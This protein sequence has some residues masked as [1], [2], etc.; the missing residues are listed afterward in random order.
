[1]RDRVLIVAS[2]VVRV[3]GWVNSLAAAGFIVAVALSFAFADAIG[4]HLLAKYP[5][6]DIALTVAMLRTMAALGLIGCVAVR[7][8]LVALGAILSSVRAGDPFVAANA[9]RL[10]RI[11]W[12]LLLL[13]V[14]DLADGM[15]VLG[16]DRL[17]V[18]HA[19]WVP[20][21]TGWVAGLMMFVLARVFRAGAAM[22]DDLA[23][24]I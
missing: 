23:M 17:G 13:Q 14:L 22:R 1:M 5:G 6:H 19:T 11:G 18:D 2:G 3:A 8:I 21:F 10:Q 9:A 15:F 12:A 16:F 4:A 24:T 7:Q 20:G